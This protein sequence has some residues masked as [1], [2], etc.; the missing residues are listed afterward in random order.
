MS[1]RF[2][3]VDGEREGRTEGR[4]LPPSL[5]PFSHLPV[6][7]MEDETDDG[8]VRG[9]ALP[10]I[11]SSAIYQSTYDVGAPLNA[12]VVASEAGDGFDDRGVGVAGATFGFFHAR[13]HARPRSGSPQNGKNQVVR[14]LARSL[15]RRKGGVQFA[16]ILPAHITHALKSPRQR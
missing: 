9:R 12:A 1:V 14:S 4:S 8:G 10:R 13:T 15:S 7:E 3:L 11:A 6:T 16:S 2:C 5:P